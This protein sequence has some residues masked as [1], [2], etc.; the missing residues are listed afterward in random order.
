MS[1]IRRA[2]ED[3]RIGLWKLAVAMHG[4]TDFVRLDFDPHKAFENLGGWIHHPDGLMLVAVA[5]ADVVG[6][7]AATFKQPWFTQNEIASE[8]LF[9]V[10]SDRRG[11]TTAFRLMQAF[12]DVARARGV[13]HVRAGVAT[14]DVGKNAGRL[15]QHFGFHPVGGS[16]SM[17]F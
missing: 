13:R 7:L 10:R 16:Y 9:Y 14:G 3:D 11:G 5:G 4:E 1:T 8:D 6:M 2:T 17:F 15:Y 12:I